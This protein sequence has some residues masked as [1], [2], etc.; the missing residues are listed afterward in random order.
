MTAALGGL[1]VS[2]SGATERYQRQD[3]VT[4]NGFRLKSQA[5]TM[6]IRINAVTINKAKAGVCAFFDVD[7][8]LW[9]AKSL[10]D[11]YEHHLCYDV[12]ASVGKA[13]VELFRS[14]IKIKQGAGFGRL[15]LNKWFYEKYFDGLNVNHVELVCKSWW[16]KKCAVPGFLHLSVID[17]AREHYMAGHQV[18][19]LTGSFELAVNPLGELLK[20]A[21]VLATP[22]EQHNGKFTG[23]LLGEPMIGEGKAYAMSEYLARLDI[24]PLACWGYSDDVSDLPFLSLLGH[25]VVVGSGDFAQS[26]MKMGWEVVEV[27]VGI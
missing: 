3:A 26:V 6:N 24:D 8:T 10:L 11:I 21:D 1:L 4:I 16:S 13:R 25:P 18:V 12:P 19:L 23:R 27:G 2:S 14:E 22:L 15:D 7:E 5:N 20:D 17:R 9:A